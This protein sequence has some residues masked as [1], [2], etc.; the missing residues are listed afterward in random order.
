MALTQK[1]TDLA[2]VA[3]FFDGE[4]SICI[5]RLKNHPTAFSGTV[6]ISQKK[7]FLLQEVLD[8]VVAYAPDYDIGATRVRSVKWSQCNGNHLPFN[9]WKGTVFLEL[10][11]PFV[12]KPK[13]RRRAEIYCR[14]FPPEKKGEHRGPER[15]DI[16]VEWLQLRVQEQKGDADGVD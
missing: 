2:W 10:I 16:F 12:R 5:T 9:Q 13:Q 14:M 6:N 15:L 4:G 7:P 11:L 1:E 8:I 3:G